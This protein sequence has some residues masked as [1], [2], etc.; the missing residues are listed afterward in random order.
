MIK[1]NA[2]QCNAEFVFYARKNYRYPVQIAVIGVENELDLP[3][4]LGILFIH[5]TF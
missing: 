4:L 5:D 2:Q 1:G 3:A